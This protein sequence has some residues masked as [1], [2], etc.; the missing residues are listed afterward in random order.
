MSSSAG[1]TVGEPAS[2][3]GSPG[4]AGPALGAGEAETDPQQRA[5]QAGRPG[6]GLATAS[7]ITGLAGITL[8]TIV[9]ALLCGVLGLRKAGRAGLRGPGAGQVRCWAG[10]GLA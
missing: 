9:P 6:N 10:I 2:D 8:V 1:R 4:S 7:L 5:G 3:P